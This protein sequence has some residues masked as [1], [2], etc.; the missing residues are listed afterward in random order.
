MP[1]LKKMSNLKKIHE[2]ARAI[3]IASHP[4]LS[5]G[6]IYETPTIV[7]S[8]YGDD[9]KQYICWLEWSAGSH[10]SSTVR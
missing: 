1:S 8:E 10:V 3:T 5:N 4:M 2:L 7:S 9:G 6:Q